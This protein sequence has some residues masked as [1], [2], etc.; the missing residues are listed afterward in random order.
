MRKYAWLILAGVVASAWWMSPRSPRT[1]LRDAAGATPWP[2][3]PH[4]RRREPTPGVF[5]LASIP[6][7]KGAP[8]RNTN[9][10]MLADSWLTASDLEH[11][12]VYFEL[13][14]RIP[15][16]NRLDQRQATLDFFHA[17]RDRLQREHDA[18]PA[19]ADKRRTIAATIERYDVAIHRLRQIIDGATPTP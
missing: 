18:L 17:Y 2:T 6:R 1:T 13:A 19:D 5:D 16:M 14:A 12:E 8:T 10:E 11:P 4:L 7:S 3:V 15:H 9:E